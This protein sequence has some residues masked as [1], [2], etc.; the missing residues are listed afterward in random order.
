MAEDVTIN[1][2]LTIPDA[3][4]EITA[5]RSSGPGGQHVNKTDTRIQIRWNMEES[6]QVSDYQRRLLRKNLS[7]RITEAGDIL[8]SCDSH[9]SQR[10]NKEEA[11]QR[12][13]AMVREALIP[14]KPRKKTKPTRAAKERR[15]QDKKQ[16]SE[17]KKG[18]GK[19]RDSD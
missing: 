9:R 1:N 3:E 6:G 8:V 4:L 16:R 11:L 5:S 14:P 10:R 15:L 18:R 17:V 7:T 2:Q 12:L 19:Y 13:A